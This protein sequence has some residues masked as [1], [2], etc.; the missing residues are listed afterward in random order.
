MQDWHLASGG[1]IDVLDY[2]NNFHRPVII[3]STQYHIELT[4]RNENR[5]IYIPRLYYGLSKLAIY[6]APFA[7]WVA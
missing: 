5:Y 2:H 7:T 6:R 4:D 3:E 1:P